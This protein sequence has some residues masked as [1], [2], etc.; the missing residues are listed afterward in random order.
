MKRMHWGSNHDFKV[1]LQPLVGG[2]KIQNHYVLY[3]LQLKAEDLGHKVRSQSPPASQ[4]PL[5]EVWQPLGSHLT[6]IVDYNSYGSNLT[7]RLS[8]SFA[9][10]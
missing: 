3:H 2:G 7:S 5:V 10:K 1:S 4:F 8:L 9:A 6:C